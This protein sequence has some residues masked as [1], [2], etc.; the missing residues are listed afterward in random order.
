MS[1]GKGIYYTSALS[2]EEQAER[3]IRRRKGGKRKKRA[4][5]AQMDHASGKTKQARQDEQRLS[6]GRS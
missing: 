6:R 3:R 1:K 4:I 2:P 5:P